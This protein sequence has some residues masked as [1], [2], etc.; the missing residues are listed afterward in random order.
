MKKG[1]KAGLDLVLTLIKE[2]KSPAQIS[3]IININKKTLWH[4]TDKLKKLGCIE[5]VAYGT[6][7]FIKEVPIIPKASVRG[8]GETSLKQIRAHA[9]TWKISFYDPIDWHKIIPPRRKIKT[10]TFH[11][12]GQ[13]KG[14]FR[15]LFNRRNG[16][17]SPSCLNLCFL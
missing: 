10:L 12:A 6:W 13:G 3:K 14:Y 4:Y 7:N 8:D 11:K 15:T 17:K 2:G 1:R 9:F 5:R 16:I